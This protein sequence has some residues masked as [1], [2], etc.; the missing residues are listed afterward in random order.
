MTRD[1]I[2]SLAKSQVGYTEQK[3]NITKYA[4]DFDT[5]W[6]DFYNTKKN[7]ASWCDIFVDW[8]FCETVGPDKA[9]EMLYQPKKSCGAGCKYSVQYYKKHNAYDKNPQVG[10]QIFFGRAGAESHTGI[11]IAVSSYSVTTIEGNSTNMVRQHVYNLTDYHIAGYG[12]PKY[13]A[14]PIDVGTTYPGTWPTLP[15][16]G[17]FQKGDKGV[18][19][20]R[21][22]EFLKWYNPAFLPKYGAD[23]DFGSETLTAVKTFQTQEHLTVDG[24]FG[25]KSLAA[26]KKVVR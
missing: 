3:N 11:V 26:A 24:L 7:G 1:L 13:E 18:N 10:D 6:P 5:K 22:Q 12:H 17:Y 23:G 20:V 8:L 15:K 16:R 14:E 19:V 9:M 2:V 25:K 21:L 4:K